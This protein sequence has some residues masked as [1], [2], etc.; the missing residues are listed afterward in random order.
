MWQ[1]A[2][3]GASFTNGGAL[4]HAFFSFSRGNEQV[5]QLDLS[6]DG[7]W[8]LVNAGEKVIRML[9]RESTTGR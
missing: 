5:K 8:M 9:E 2:A 1:T 6:R 4:V 3:E 7:K